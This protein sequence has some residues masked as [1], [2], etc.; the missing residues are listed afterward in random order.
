M[1]GT[2]QGFGDA[3]VEA[4]A[5]PAQ[6]AIDRAHGAVEAAGH[7][8]QAEIFVVTKM[9]DFAVVGGQFREAI[10]QDALALFQMIGAAVGFLGHGAE[11]ILAKV[12]AVALLALAV[13]E[14][15]VKGDLARPCAEIRAEFELRKVPPHDDLGLLQNIVGILR[16][17]HHRHDVSAQRPLVA[18]EQENEFFGGIGR[19]HVRGVLQISPARHGIGH[20][21]S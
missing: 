9:E 2:R 5:H 8:F 14:D 21:F 12:E 16:M 19:G 20:V 15:L 10:V 3:I 1:V 13:G 7:I 4:V 11:E 17:R 18:G 6:E